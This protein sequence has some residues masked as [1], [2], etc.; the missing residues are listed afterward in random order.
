M[1]MPGFMWVDCEECGGSGNFEYDTCRACMGEG[2]RW[3]P[4]P[5]P[6]PTPATEDQ[7]PPPDSH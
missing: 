4:I 6:D 3:L 1:V 7:A 5:P 2:G